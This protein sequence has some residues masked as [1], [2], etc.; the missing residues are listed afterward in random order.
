M[1]QYVILFVK[2]Y[3]IVFEIV[4]NVFVVNTVELKIFLDLYIS[5]TIHGFVRNDVDVV[6]AFVIVVGEQFFDRR[7]SG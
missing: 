4:T 7:K 5:F 6:V 2:I 3:L 1:M